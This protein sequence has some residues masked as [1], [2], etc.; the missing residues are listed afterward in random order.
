M[1]IAQACLANRLKR[2]LAWAMGSFGWLL[3]GH[4]RIS[5]S[6]CD[7]NICRILPSLTHCQFLHHNMLVVDAIWAK[8][9]LAL[10]KFLEQLGVVQ[11]SLLQLAFFQTQDWRSNGGSLLRAMN[12][13][14]MKL[15]K[16]CVVGS[17]VLCWYPSLLDVGMTTK[18]QLGG[19]TRLFARHRMHAMRLW[20]PTKWASRDMRNSR[21]ISMWGFP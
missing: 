13:Q 11:S 12:L 7:Y 15:V 20:K 5:A 8:S 21:I 14:F 19:C 2:P 4:L 3:D 6:V 18:G 16:F 17:C 1:T 9:R 10:R